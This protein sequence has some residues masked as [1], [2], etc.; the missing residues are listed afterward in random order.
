MTERDKRYLKVV[1]DAKGAIGGEN[2]AQQL[3]IEVSEVENDIEPFLLRL[4]LLSKGPT[5]RELTER[6]KGFL[7]GTK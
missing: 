4:G 6:G 3:G 1:A 2:I 5:G 7:E